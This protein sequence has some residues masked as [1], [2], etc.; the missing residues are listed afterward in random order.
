MGAPLSDEAVGHEDIVHWTGSFQNWNSRCAACHS[1]NLE[2]NYSR[3]S[4]SYETSWSEINVA[5]EACHGPAS[6]HLAWAV[7]DRGDDSKG[8][9]FSLGDR[10][11]GAP[12]SLRR[13]AAQ[14]TP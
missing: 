3:N 14:P 1:T 8:F 5:C 13:T 9:S 6:S 4:N 10:G 7:G 11:P 2:K 12:A